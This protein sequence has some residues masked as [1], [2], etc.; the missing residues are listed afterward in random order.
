[1]LSDGTYKAEFVLPERLLSNDVSLN[2]VLSA[3]AV[4]NV[5]NITGKDKEHPNG[6]PVTPDKVNSDFKSSK[7]DY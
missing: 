7:T 2:A 5:G 4:D 3:V 1:L 6:V